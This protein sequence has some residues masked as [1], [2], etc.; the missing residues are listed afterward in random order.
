LYN[1]LLLGRHYNNAKKKINHGSNSKL[2]IEKM[3]QAIFYEKN[4]KNI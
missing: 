1:E 2:T 4:Y 3:I